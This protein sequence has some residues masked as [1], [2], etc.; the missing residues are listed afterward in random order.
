MGVILPI[1]LP[2][3]M[4]NVVIGMT[5]PMV[6]PV[7]LISDDSQRKTQI[8]PYH[9][10]VST[11]PFHGK[12]TLSYK[13][14]ARGKVSKIPYKEKAW[15][16]PGLI[17][18][19]N[20]IEEC[21]TQLTLVENVQALILVNFELLSSNT[22]KLTW[23]GNNVPSF[24]IMKKSETDE[25]FIADKRYSWNDEYAIVEIRSE[26]YN[27]FLQGTSNSGS[28]AVYTIGAVNNLLVLPEIDVAL[29][30]KIHTAVIEYTSVYKIEINY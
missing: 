15:F 18:S 17:L 14:N 30:D 11:K 23:Y 26:D 10:S 12:T 8:V 19:E 24:T 5:L 1:N 9:E 2:T 29:N 3:T 20:V 13:E 21:S 22:L 28:S 6:L 25:E 7:S 4:N 16:F 27:I